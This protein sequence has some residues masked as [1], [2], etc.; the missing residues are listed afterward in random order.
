MSVAV[1]ASNHCCAKCLNSGVKMRNWCTERVDVDDV[2]ASFRRTMLA[3]QAVGVLVLNGHAVLQ[4][5]LG[6]CCRRRVWRV[7]VDVAAN[8]T[9]DAL[10]FSRETKPSDSCGGKR[11]TN[12]DF[13]V[14][15]PLISLKSQHSHIAVKL[16][17]GIK[18]DWVLCWERNP[19][20]TP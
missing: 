11:L 13:S 2:E 14:D 10:D 18:E 12:G 17:N 15:H 6:L 5:C 8:H 3:E 4:D 20:Q 7:Y 9:F 16:H 1:A 19:G